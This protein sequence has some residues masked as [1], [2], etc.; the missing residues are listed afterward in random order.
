MEKATREA[1]QHTSWINPQQDYDAALRQFISAV[2]DPEQS[3]AFLDEI[4]ALAT[5]CAFY[6]QVNSLAQ[7]LLKF[8]APGVPDLY[9]GCELWDLSLVD[10]DNRRP[11]DYGLRRGF[12]AELRASTDGAGKALGNLCR[13]LLATSTDGRVKLYLTERALAL[14]R[15][16]PELFAAGDYVPLDAH[17]TFREHVV[18]YARVMGDQVALVVVPRLVAT[19]GG[20]QMRFP[21]G[22]ATW[23]DTWIALPPELAERRFTS[24]LT[25]EQLWPVDREGQPG[26]ALADLLASFPV[27]LMEGQ[28]E[29]A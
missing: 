1:K 4:G 17:G 25:G 16:L 10:P 20:D 9:Q 21:L 26:L 12:L 14:R 27:A 3:S 2:M 18:A 15:A 5:R 24:W 13:D 29:V 23:A 6:G 8:T 19:L 28:H 7:T 11:V 22:A